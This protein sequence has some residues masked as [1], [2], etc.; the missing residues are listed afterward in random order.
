MPAPKASTGFAL[1]PGPLDPREERREIGRLNR[2]STPDAKAWRSIPVA[3]D[4]VCH[5]LV[6]ES[7]D[8]FFEARPL[9]GLVLGEEVGVTDRD[10]NRGT[11]AMGRRLWPEISPR[12]SPP[13]S[14]TPPL[15]SPGSAQSEPLAPP[16]LR[17]NGV[18]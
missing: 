13:P 2:G 12:E 3:G 17:P 18:R 8:K 16:A 4:V 10:A 15:D 9:R 5:T 11:R 14:R 6:A 7:G 1:L